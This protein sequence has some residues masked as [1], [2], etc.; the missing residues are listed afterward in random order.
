MNPIKTGDI[1]PSFY[2]SDEDGNM[3]DI[4]TVPG[5]S[6]TRPTMVH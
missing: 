1:I 6:F 5:I 2:L 4:I 3:F